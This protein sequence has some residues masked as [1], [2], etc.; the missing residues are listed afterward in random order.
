MVGTGNGSVPLAGLA[1]VESGVPANDPVVALL[2][3]S[4]RD[5]ALSVNG[6]YAISLYIMFLDRLG[7]KDDEPLIQ[8]LTLRLLT[9]QCPDGSWSYTCGGLLLDPVE[10]RTLY[11]ELTRGAR[12]A[13]PDALPKAK[14]KE[15]RP[16]E[17]LDD[18]PKPGKKDEAPPAPKEEKPK[19]LHPALERY[20]RRAREVTPGS[21]GG[22]GF[23][24]ATAGDHSNTQFAT[25]GLWCGRRHHVDVS[26]ALAGLDKH[27]R[28]CQAED[29]GWGYTVVLGGASP[30]MT[31]AGL[32]GLAMGFA[33]D[34]KDGPDQ[35][36]RLDADA[37]AKDR[38]LERGLKYVGDFLA[39]AGGQRDPR[40]GMFQANDLSGNLYFMWSLER[41]GMVYGLTTI[42][43]VDWY[44]WG[45]KILVRNQNRDGSW[46]T[47]SQGTVD[48]ATAFALLFLSRANLAEDL[49]TSMKGKVKD[50]GTS[51][52]RSPADLNEMLG[53]A[54]KGSSGTKS[55]P[56]ATRPKADPP[57]ATPSAGKLAAALVAADGAE[58]DALMAK[59]RDTKGVEYTDAL[60]Q[61]IP[62]L[63]GEARR[64][65][66][67]PWPVGRPGSHPT[68]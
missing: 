18:K 63:T 47:N 35:A 68:P 27:Y 34:V 42:G 55:D 29:G 33:K 45:S 32:M 59:Y 16:R 60:A 66:A 13:T 9:G 26:A 52:L 1:L 36:V 8:F 49:A 44:D 56:G 41:V 37:L 21:G 2:A 20:A 14:K 30:A 25:V 61:A 19:G 62:K 23:G 40:S 10:Q 7:S 3:R 12:V 43:K 5:Q 57:A 38:S 51:R 50:P 46:S 11:A 31:C 6:T 28:Q 15:P 53:K 22:V 4:V 54:G 17:D 67:T 48:N 64:R 65:P 39:A 24:V 58:R